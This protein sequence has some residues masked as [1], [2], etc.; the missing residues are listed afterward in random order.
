MHIRQAT[1]DDAEEFLDYLA[2]FWAD[3]CDTVNYKSSFPNLEQ[4]REWLSRRDGED[5]IV[6]VAEQDSRIM[7]MIDA[8][9]PKAAEHRHTCEFGMSV[10]LQFRKQGIG[11][12]LLQHFLDWAEDRS[13][14]KVELDVFSNNSPAIA[15]YSDLGFSEDGRREKA[16]KLRNGVFCDLVH[17]SKYTE[18]A[19][20]A[21]Q[22]IS[23]AGGGSSTRRSDEL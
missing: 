22:R 13:L 4:E 21:L 19:N 15:L 7:G 12:K 10:L 6:F 14:W 16:V 18:T 2:V 9:V 3:G 1:I 23:P 11:R 17:M 5:A 20:K 8:A